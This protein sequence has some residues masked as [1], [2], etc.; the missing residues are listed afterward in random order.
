LLDSY[1]SVVTS[2]DDSDMES[3]RE[4]HMDSGNCRFS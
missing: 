3:D 4:S 1:K 2:N